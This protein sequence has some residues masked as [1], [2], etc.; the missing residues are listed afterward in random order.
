MFQF[1]AEIG[2]FEIGNASLVDTLLHLY[3][4]PDKPGILLWEN[5]KL[6]GRACWVLFC[7]LL[8]FCSFFSRA[9]TGALDAATGQLLALTN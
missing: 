4:Q 5:T 8:L 1:N 9:E 2:H 3:I 7:G 6:L